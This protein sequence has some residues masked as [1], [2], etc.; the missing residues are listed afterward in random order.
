MA[1][2]RAV[3]ARDPTKE[4]PMAHGVS[5]SEFKLPP[6]TPGPHR[7]RL[8]LVALVATFG[9]LLFGYDTG[10]ANG[11]ERPLAHE[12]GFDALQ[13]GIVISALIFAAAVG[14]MVCG[15]IAD[16]IGRKPTII[17]LAVLF[18]CGTA[19]V[20]TS[21][22]GPELGTHT[23]F[24]YAMLITGRICLGLA[25]GGASAVVPVYLAEL[26]PFEIRG[27]LS[28]RNEFMIVV[29]QLAAFVVNAIIAAVMGLDTP[30]LW[31]VMFSICAI[32]A[33]F[34]FFGMLRMPESP[35]WLVEK[36]RQEDARAVLLT[37]RSKERA[38]AELAEVENVAAEEHELEG[39]RLGFAAVLK[40]KSLLVILV[41]A[42]CLGIA[43]QFTGVNAIMYYGQRMLAE[44]GFSEDMI[45]W[46]NIAP[47]VIAV[48]GGVVALFLM[49]RINRR[50]NFLWGYGMTALSHILIAIAMMLLF[51]EGSAARPWVFL[52]LIIVMIGS[53]Q[54]FLNLATWV[55]LSEIFPLH[56]R[57]IGMG[58][59]VLVLWLANGV[60]ALLVPSIV[61]A[62][63]MG[64]F[65]IF[66]VVNVVSFLF[67][68]RFLPETRGRT[69]EELEEDVTTGA[70]LLPAARR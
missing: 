20:V 15:Q 53:I 29:G 5:A 46:V 61:N 27:S 25:V 69:L 56:M 48:L 58:V 65:L 22:G 14:A 1:L 16:K 51:P 33:I 57:G 12:M 10:V 59:S 4:S 28:G 3:G 8:G 40:N 45:G 55:Y 50:T 2:S 68:F 26:A 39:A 49:D 54:L 24:G 23:A 70:I 6:L 41:I 43:Q 11:A 37:I 42:C 31:R 66:A 32:P 13:I 47:G 17:I 9:G 30:G 64:L 7:K 36:G 44:S 52:V 19:I 18:F 63:G 62:V 21:P 35:R 34:L 67:I 38:E 60:L